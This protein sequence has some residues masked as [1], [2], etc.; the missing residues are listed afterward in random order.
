MANPSREKGTRYEVACAEWFQQQG[1]SEVFRMATRATLD[2]GD[3]GGLPRFAVE[4]RDRQKQSLALNVDDAVSRARNKGAD[5]GVALMKRP[6]HPI[7]DSYVLMSLGTFGRILDE[8]LVEE[9]RAQSPP[10]ESSVSK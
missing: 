6:R 3:L 8:L 1:W 7:C 5:F 2:V 9:K 4:C 10:E